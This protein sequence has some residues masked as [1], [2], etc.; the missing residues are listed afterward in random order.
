MPGNRIEV[1]PPEP[2]ESGICAR[3]RSQVEAIGTAELQTAMDKL[4]SRADPATAHPDILE[5]MTWEIVQ[6]VAIEPILDQSSGEPDIK[7]EAVV[8]LFLSRVQ[9]TASVD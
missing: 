7:N 3:L 5:E 8:N 6:Q 2:R 1:S 4:D 9:E